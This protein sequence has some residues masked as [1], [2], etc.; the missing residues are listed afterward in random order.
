MFIVKHIYPKK[1]N[2]KTKKNREKKWIERDSINE[3]NECRWM[4]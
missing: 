2:T 1:K 3:G 4:R